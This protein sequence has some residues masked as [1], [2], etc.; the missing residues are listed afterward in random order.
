MELPPQASPT[1]ENAKWELGCGF[2]TRTL[3]KLILDKMN[4]SIPRM[5]YTLL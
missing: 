4:D 5:N 3:E 2:M 1:S